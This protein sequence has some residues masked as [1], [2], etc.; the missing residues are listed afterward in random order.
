MATQEH[1]AILK[2]GVKKW[3]Q[4][5]KEH[6]DIKPNLSFADL[7]RAKLRFANLSNVNLIRTNFS[8]AALSGADFSGA[9]IG[10]TIFANVDLRLVKGL[11]TVE[12]GGPSSIGI[13]TIYRSKSMIPDDFLQGAGIPDT[14]IDYVRSL[15]IKPFDYYTCFI[16]YSSHDEN[17]AKRLYVDLQSNGVRCWFAPEDMKIGDKI[18]HRI[19]ESIRLYDKLLLVLSARSVASEWVEH[20]VEM[21]LAKERQEKRT[22]L[23]PIRLDNTIIEMEQDGWP[24]EVR[25]TRHIGDFTRWKQHD[26]YQQA[27]E[28]LLRDLKAE[29]L[30]QTP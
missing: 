8:D 20:E 21:A 16:S 18:R 25:H 29:S 14:F 15:A 22:V 13:D 4:W 10:W 23:F 6:P 7:S 9:T 5:R 12:H 2:Q 19:D 27:F 26:D 3:N 1:L 11:E 28:R 24:A 17:F 30:S